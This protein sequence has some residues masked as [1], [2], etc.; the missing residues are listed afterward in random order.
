M[1]SEA[2]GFLTH[3]FE[4]WEPLD[5][6]SWPFLADESRGTRAKLWLRDES[7]TQWLRKSPK[8]GADGFVNRPWE[9]SIE[10]FVLR[11][12]RSIGLPAPPSHVCCWRED[13][14]SVSRGIVVENFL[15]R[16]K[17][18]SL[19]L[20]RELL[21]GLQPEYDREQREHHTLERVRQALTVTAERNRAA[22]L[23]SPFV[24]I[25]LFD[26]WLGILD[27]HQENWGVLRCRDGSVELAPLYDVAACLGAELTA[28]PLL[29]EAPPSN[30]RLEAYIRKC[31]SGFGDGQNHRLLSQEA[32]VR[33]FRTWPE[34]KMRWTWWEPRFRAALPTATE[35]LGSVPEGW[36]PRVRCRLASSLLS[37]RLEWLREIADEGA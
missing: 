24:D 34:W 23:L 26:A 8:L 33:T 17:H 11:L 37:C 21:E 18:E 20:G 15:N 19:I 12:A 31:P 1:S 2:A 7:G 29:Q 16:S 30:V 36:L 14:G 27:R 22:D 4:P 25:L 3:A 5:V 10:A 6:S 9:N 32:V 35:Y 13:D 28:S